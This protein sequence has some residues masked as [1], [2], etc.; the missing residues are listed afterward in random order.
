VNLWQISEDIFDP[1]RLHSRETV[2]TI[3]NG[4]FGTRGTF[5]EGYPGAMPA[6]LLFG[7]FDDIAIGKEEL[8]NAPDWLLLK[9][10]INGER[11]RLD[12]GIVLEYHRTVDMQNGLLSRFVHWES[13]GGIRLKIT[14]ER[15]AS[16]AYEHVG[17][18]RY[19]VTTEEQTT[20]AQTGGQA[21][22]D[23]VL[24]ASLNIAVGNNDLMHWE[25][26]D[27][28]CENELLWLHTQTR[29]SHVQLA[30]S[31]SFT[32][33]AEGFERE[34]F[35]SDIAPG[36]RL[37]GKLAH[38][39][40]LTAEKI[41]TMYTSRESDNPV[42]S[43]LDLHGSILHAG[44]AGLFAQHKEA[45]LD[46]WRVSDIIIEGDDKAQQAIRFNIYQLRINVSA[47]DSRYSIAA[48]G[49]TGFA[50][51]G[52]IFHDTENFMLPFF[53]YIQPA[54]ARN[55]L[56]FRYH[57][58][59]AARE[60]AS[61]NGFEGAQ[62]PWESG[63]NGE[64]AT[65]ETMIH[66]EIGTLISVPHGKRE[67]H[68]TADIAYR[69]WQYWYITGDDEFMRD[70]GAELLLSTAM[71]WA[72]RAERHP[73]RHDYEI[74]NVVGPDEWHEHMNNNAYTNYMARRNIQDG[75]DVIDWLSTYAPI[76]ARE[77]E[78]QLDLNDAR[79]NHWRDV[80]T[81]MYFPQDKQTGLIEEF[82]GFFQLES[83]D[84]N[85]YKGR[86]TSYQGILG[87]DPVQRY[88]IVKQADVLMLLTLMGE[89]FSLET[90]RVN[91]DYYYPITDHDYGSSLTPALH[92]I[93]ACELS[94][95]DKAYELY[96]I[97]ALTD[98]ED[99]RLNAAGGIH[100]AS[101]GAVWQA[102]ILGFA[103][104]RVTDEGYS[105]SPSWPNGWTRLAF[106]FQHKGKSISVDLRKT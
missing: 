90:K 59:P 66:P 41:V 18:I 60:K 104:L 96:M 21:D 24:W 45:W 63:L 31:M 82:D 102:T 15:F 27:Q 79:L 1:K 34:V 65:P 101:C 33:Q 30:Q 49:L 20:A 12:R 86:T 98:L 29:H 48:K 16:L 56:L 9:L 14:V 84:Q 13:P 57:L 103:G 93:L 52:H 55:L 100:E 80:V 61:E 85:T 54:I 97:G 47:H 99:L 28:G 5:E 35:D 42:K 92:V 78:K 2:Y 7:V 68:I 62:Y 87:M 46:F 83:L 44:F 105:T 81:N 17:A 51:H 50:Y 22:L 38:G 26:V 37:Q 19:S 70:Y 40:T 6:T 3:G 11:F 74:N 58:L 36:I 95:I 69:F 23:V 88:Q 91:W 72:S 94:K 73:Q 4:Y 53:M 106:T 25:T 64:E 71:F 76:K 10:F 39:A 43:S 67:L 8:A 75:L 77:L 89:Y 32:T